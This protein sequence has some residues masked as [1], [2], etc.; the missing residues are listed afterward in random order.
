MEGSQKYDFS[1]KISNNLWENEV[2]SLYP[3]PQ[4]K[5]L[6]SRQLRYSCKEEVNRLIWTAGIGRKNTFLGFSVI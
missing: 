4:S 5:M 1:S 6:V 3:G 2:N